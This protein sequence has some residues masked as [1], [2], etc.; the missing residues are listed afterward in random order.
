LFLLGENDRAL[1][2]TDMVIRLEPRQPLAYVNRG[3]ILNDM[4]D[5]AGAIASINKAL[6]LVPGFPPALKALKEIGADKIKK[7]R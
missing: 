5:R 2:D 6:K 7:A 4:G 1:A 3:K